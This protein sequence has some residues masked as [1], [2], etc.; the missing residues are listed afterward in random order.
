MVPSLVNEQV[1]CT[2][3]YLST[4]SKSVGRYLRRISKRKFLKMLDA[5][6]AARYEFISAYPSRGCRGSWTPSFALLR[7]ARDRCGEVMCVVLQ[8]VSAGVSK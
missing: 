7:H 6:K 8:V 5:N 4:Y 1:W 3:I 2:L